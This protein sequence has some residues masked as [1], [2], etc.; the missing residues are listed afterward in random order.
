VA[1]PPAGPSLLL[2]ARA[3]SGRIEERENGTYRMVLDRVDEID[4][5]T[6]RPDRVEATW[7]PQKSISQWKSFF[8]TSEPNAQASFKVGEKRELIT[9]E[10]FK[11]E[12]NSKNQ[13]LSI[14]IDAGTINNL[15]SDLITGLKGKALDE[16]TLFIDDAV[17][18]Q[19]KVVAYGYNRT[20]ERILMDLGNISPSNFVTVDEIED[21]TNALNAG[22]VSG[23]LVDARKDMETAKSVIESSGSTPVLAMTRDLAADTIMAL[24]GACD[25]L[26]I[27]FTSEVFN[28]RLIKCGII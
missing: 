24:S 26:V 15:E 8:E 3:D 25:I 14:R 16:V 11:P 12:L 7:K 9:F 5:F 19:D 1:K 6:D 28:E 10:M 21:L 4:W 17:V 22:N 13:K 27:P 20:T 23:V 18:S 2:R